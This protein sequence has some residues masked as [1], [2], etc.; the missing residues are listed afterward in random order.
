MVNDAG[1]WERRQARE[2]TETLALNTEPADEA[3]ESDDPATL[4][5]SIDPG[6]EAVN[7]HVQCASV[8]GSS[9]LPRVEGAFS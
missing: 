2:L 1:V 8:R 4:E 9:A 3:A 5:Q 7:L 6:G